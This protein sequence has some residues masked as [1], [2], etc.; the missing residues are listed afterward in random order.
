MGAEP[1][2]KNHL[3][4][5]WDAD[6]KEHKEISDRAWAEGNRRFSARAAASRVAAEAAFKGIEAGIYGAVTVVSGEQALKATK[7]KKPSFRQ[8]PRHKEHVKKQ[9]TIEQAFRGIASGGPVRADDAMDVDQPRGRRR[10]GEDHLSQLRFRYYTSAAMRSRRKMVR[11]RRYRGRKRRRMGVRRRG[12][13]LKWYRK[14]KRSYKRKNW[15]YSIVKSLK[16]KVIEFNWPFALTNQSFQN[17]TVAVPMFDRQNQCST[18]DLGSGLNA[19]GDTQRQAADIDSPTVWG[20]LY[21]AAGFNP[22]QDASTL[23]MCIFGPRYYRWQFV[24]QE[25]HPISMTIYWCKP[26]EDYFINNTALNTVSPQAGYITQGSDL[27]DIWSRCLFRDNIANYTAGCLAGLPSSFTPF[28]SKSFCS[29][30]K[31][32]RVKKY[33]LDSGDCMALKHKS[34][35]WVN[36]TDLKATDIST[37]IAKARGHIFPLIQVNGCLVYDSTTPNK[38]GQGFARVSCEWTCRVKQ[39]LYSS[40]GQSFAKYNLFAPAGAVVAGVYTSKPVAAQVNQN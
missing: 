30:F 38:V 35:N 19:Y 27:N 12:T 20:N 28:D 24:N 3:D 33:E 26:R 37:K 15:A 23:Q 5:M 10:G 34:K 4:K 1:P 18:S 14:K 39:Y 29:L 36:F 6:W 21:S 11:R 8:R 32:I 16:P 25:T 13:G 40:T 17:C 7:R 9:Q 31:V 2:K 22:A